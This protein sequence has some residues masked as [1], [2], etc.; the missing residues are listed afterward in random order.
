MKV[1]IS[2]CLIMAGSCGSNRGGIPV[3][4]SGS[5]CG[6]NCTIYL[7]DYQQKW[8]QWKRGSKMEKVFF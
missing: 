4:Q 3:G 2:S 7:I 5:I 8:K 1:S 6:S